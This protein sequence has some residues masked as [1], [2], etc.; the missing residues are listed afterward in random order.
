[1]SQAVF[2]FAHPSALAFD[3]ALALDSG[4]LRNTRPLGMGS[5]RFRR[6]HLDFC[7]SSCQ[8]LIWRTKPRPPRL[9]AAGLAGVHFVA[10]LYKKSLYNIE[11]AFSPAFL[12]VERVDRRRPAFS[13]FA[14]ELKL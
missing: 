3:L 5:E 12:C 4:D 14:G 7:S 10:G 6:Q 1:M 11:I 13:A 8:H 9:A 2:V